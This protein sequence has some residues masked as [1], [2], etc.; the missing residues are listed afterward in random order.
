MEN[1]TR[2][3]R[4]DRMISRGEDFSD[5]WADSGDPVKIKAPMNTSKVKFKAAIEQMG[6]DEMSDI[7]GFD[8]SR[9][10]GFVNG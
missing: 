4:N 9:S 7:R 6:D 8:R 1:D 5:L 3:F 2:Y 10:G